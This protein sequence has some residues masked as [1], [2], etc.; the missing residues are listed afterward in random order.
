MKQGILRFLFL[1][2]VFDF[3]QVNFSWINVAIC[4]L[5]IALENVP[6]NFSSTY[7]SQIV[8]YQT[9]VTVTILPI[10]NR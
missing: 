3:S 7:S 10:H 2:H 4:D 6:L 1:G 9:G 5:V 8:V